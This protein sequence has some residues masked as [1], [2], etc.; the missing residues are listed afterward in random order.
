[1]REFIK[2]TIPNENYKKEV[3][4]EMKEQTLSF[5]K[6]GAGALFRCP[7]CDGP[8][9]VESGYGGGVAECPHCDTVLRFT[10]HQL[11]VVTGI[12]ASVNDGLTP[13]ERRV[14]REL[15]V[16]P[17]EARQAKEG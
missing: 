3:K 15:G 14:S 12:K 16:S 9:D 5:A 13:H 8:L 4:A 10:S 6:G 7:A 17:E 1:M 2:V 11:E